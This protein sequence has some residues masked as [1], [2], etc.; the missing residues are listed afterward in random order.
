[1]GIIFNVLV[2]SPTLGPSIRWEAPSWSHLGGIIILISSP[3]S[4]AQHCN[5]ATLLAGRWVVLLF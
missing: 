5:Y 4:L 3:D 2:S 1:M